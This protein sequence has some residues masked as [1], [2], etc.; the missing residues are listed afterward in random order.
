MELAGIEAACLILD[1]AVG[2]GGEV[3]VFEIPEC[4]RL[5]GSVGERRPDIRRLAVTLDE[6]HDVNAFWAA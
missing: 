3:A 4:Y 2:V 6:A 5:A 1:G